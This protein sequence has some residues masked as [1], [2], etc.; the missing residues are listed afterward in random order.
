MTLKA[1]YKKHT[2]Q[3]RFDAGTSRGV[4][5]TREVWFIKIWEKN[6]PD[7]IGIGEAAPL[8]G[9][10]TDNPMTFE[11]TLKEA[12]AALEKYNAASGK[13]Y[14]HLPMRDFPSIQFAIETALADL[15]N[16]GR[17]MIFDNSFSKG[18]AA[19]PINGLVW[20]GEAAFMKS[21][22]LDKIASGFKCIK[23][24]VGA[25][26]F[27]VECAL[28]KYIRE[29]LDEKIEI[30]LDANGA[31]SET[32]ALKKI[33]TLQPYNIHSIEQPVK[34]G[35]KSAMKE[36]CRLSPIPIALDEEL[37]G[38]FSMEH[39]ID[40]IG[41]LSPGFIV[42]KPTLLGGFASVKEWIN[43]TKINTTGWWITSALESNIGLS[44]IAQFTHDQQPAIH[45][46]LGTGKLYYNNIDSPL[47][48]HDGSLLYDAGSVWDL[49]LLR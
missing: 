32:E 2:L 28:L 24:K 31:F 23:I 49:S 14:E 42:L 3:F 35:S 46:G 17:R 5:K 19:I 47:V 27:G 22:V 36:I 25:L 11:H 37:I 9:L 30:R 16:G 18:A 39:K 1:T 38:V 21:Q 33:E 6:N 45:Q 13:M 44:A 40:L 10:S 41:E 15:N 29:N 12:I 7:C 34:Q 26:D 20:M 48:I 43:A 8:A 4:M